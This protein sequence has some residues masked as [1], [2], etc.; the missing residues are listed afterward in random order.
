MTSA[1][2]VA[3]LPQG[4]VGIVIGASRGIGAAAARALARAGATVVL[5]ARTE[6]ELVAI[7]GQITE[8]GGRAF[9]LVTDVTDPASIE[10][11]VRDTVAVHGRLDL[12]LTT[13]GRGI[14]PCRWRT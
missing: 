12:G 9:P 13:P 5:A 4:T 11:V 7:A 1:H 2:P 6:P 14:S 3:E 10:L 8:A